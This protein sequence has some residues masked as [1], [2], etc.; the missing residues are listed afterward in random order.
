MVTALAHAAR[1]KEPRRDP[2]PTC[3]LA[4]VRPRERRAD[5]LS[6]D[7]SD[8]A[9]LLRPAVDLGAHGVLR[10]R[11]E[12]LRA[13]R[14]QPRAGPYGPSQ[15][16]RRPGCSAASRSTLSVG[17]AESSQYVTRRLVADDA[18]P[19][20]V[21]ARAQRRASSSPRATRT[22]PRVLWRRGIS[23]RGYCPR[24]R[25]SRL[26]VSPDRDPRSPSVAAFVVRSLATAVAHL[27]YDSCALC[28]RRAEV[29][30]FDLGIFLN[31]SDRRPR[32]AR[33]RTRT[34]TGIGHYLGYVYPPLARVRHDPCWPS[35]PPTRRLRASGRS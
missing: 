1:G 24:V 23:R 22:Y 19:P 27:Y 3:D 20:D 17:A 11:R 33:R 28:T 18:P 15:A 6:V 8:D 10:E 2:L 30:A 12:Q 34:S 35:L 29:V 5:P 9:R 32:T 14:G 21:L 26:V 16:S 13:A 25:W 7:G 4:A 31:A